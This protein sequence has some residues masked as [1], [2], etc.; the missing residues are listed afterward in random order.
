MH[1]CIHAYMHACIHAYMH[2]CIHAYMHACIHA[3]M[4]SFIYMADSPGLARVP[5]VASARGV[6]DLPTTTNNN[7]RLSLL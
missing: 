6:H 3:Y 1:T 2:T 5:L 4:H 7:Y